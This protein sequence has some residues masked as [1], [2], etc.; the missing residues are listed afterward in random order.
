MK[1]VE[2]EIDGEKY[3]VKDSSTILDACQKNN[4]WI[5]TLCSHRDLPPYG[6][7]R[8]CI[9]H[10]EGMRGYPPACTTPVSDGMVVTTES[11]E[12]KKL[13]KGILE[14]ILSE[15]PSGCLFCMDK[16]MC[17]KY[18]VCHTKAGRVTGCETCPNNGQ[19]ELQEVMEN[20]GLDDLNLPQHYRELPLERDDPFFERDYNL[21]ILCGRCVRVCSEIRGIGAI[22]LTKRGHDTKVGTAFGK[23]HLDGGCEFCGA[24]VDVCPTGSLSAKGTKWH[25]S[26]ERTVETTCIL[27]GVGC[28]IH[29]ECKWDRILSTCPDENGPANK[30]QLCVK[31]RF[32]IAP[33]VNHP[34][35][36]KFPL[37]RKGGHL[38]PVD[39]EEAI[40]YVCERLKGFTEEKVG[41]LASPYLTNE[42]AYVMQ[43][44][45]REVIRTPN[46]DNTSLLSGTII[47]ALHPAVGAG[48][49]SGKIRSMEGSDVIVVVGAELCHTHP[50]L[51]VNIV[52][53][54]KSGGKHILVTPDD[55]GQPR[56]MDMHIKTDDYIGLFSSVL[57]RLVKD[58][59]V[60]ESIGTTSEGDDSKTL[61]SLVE[62]KKVTILFGEG[63]LKCSDPAR[64]VT[65]LYDISIATGNPKGLIP[66]WTEGNAQGV[67]DVGALPGFL[68]GWEPS[69]N[70]GLSYSDMIDGKVKALFTTEALPKRPEGLEFCVYQGVYPSDVMEY[71]DVVLP[72]AAFTEVDGTITNAERRVSPIKKC[73]GPPGMALPDCDILSKVAKGLG[74]EGFDYKDS[75]DVTGEIFGKHFKTREGIW[76]LRRVELKLVPL[77]SGSD[78]RIKEAP[79]RYRGGDLVELVEDLNILYSA[80][81][82]DK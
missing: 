17:K 53:A 34:K 50:V 75:S 80:R 67:C 31:G 58:D 42:A 9:V 11:E 22:A 39:W 77:R 70:V 82:V 62:G 65:I 54:R 30:G 16:E 63:I 44:L 14:L 68:P 47:N 20:I 8:M 74:G 55:A 13:R 7:C 45:A 1:V 21:C 71:A 81:G 15:H 25:A 48:A 36:L 73:V 19:C 57:K 40:S 12:L 18:H 69:E 26:P 35:R 28:S 66:L 4:I 3:P 32:C 37:I 38:T 23:S 2:I 24:C 59:A 52:K 64:L 6:A 41:F 76:Q 60:I 79:S 72:A 5:P 78:V 49:G 56:S 51:G 33:L 27:C 29:T 61:S 43:K 46:I 10:V